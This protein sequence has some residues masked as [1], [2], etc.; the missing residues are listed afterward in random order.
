M[1]RVMTTNPLPDGSYR[2]VSALGRDANVEQESYEV[3]QAVP[4]RAA[5]S[6]EHTQQLGPACSC[7]ATHLLHDGT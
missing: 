7:P 3:C 6:A 2:G 5:L 1:Y 4:Q